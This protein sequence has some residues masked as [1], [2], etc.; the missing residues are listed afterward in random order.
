MRMILDGRVPERRLAI[1][2]GVAVCLL[3]TAGSAVASSTSMSKDE[4]AAQQAAQQI[5]DSFTPPDAP[6][7]SYFGV[8]AG[9]VDPDPSTT[10]DPHPLLTTV[11]NAMNSLD[12]GGFSGA[13]Q[14]PDGVIHVGLTGGG[15]PQLLQTLTSALPG[16]DTQVF[17]TK[18]S[19]TDL[20]TIADDVVD[21]MASDVT[22]T[23]LSV[24]PDIASNAVQ[25]GVTDVNSPIAT[26]IAQ[27]YGDAVDLFRDS[28][29]T[30]LDAAP[31]STPYPGRA[32]HHQPGYA[33]L[34]IYVPKGTPG[35][36]H[37]GACTSGFGYHFG[38]V[39]GP[40]YET[41]FYTAGH[42]VILQ[43]PTTVWDQGGG[44]FGPWTRRSYNP[45]AFLTLADAATITTNNN[46]TI[47]YRDSSNLVAIAP[48]V[49]PVEIT[50]RE[51]LY[52]GAKGDPV[53]VS[54]AISGVRTGTIT[55]GGFGTTFKLSGGTIV[56]SAY[57]ATLTG[58]LKPG[59]SG[60][61]VFEHG[62]ALGSLVGASEA[63]PKVVYYSQIGYVES[64]LG[65]DTNTSTVTY[66]S[67]PDLPRS[68]K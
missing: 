54:G 42:C 16:T 63:N 28:P 32:V 47:T 56:A 36:P 34:Y 66:H 26:A 48:G 17:S 12:P 43:P 60:A 52:K 3:M 25:V 62:V 61:P 19:L 65:V 53:E 21:E 20:L 45:G 27:Q 18:Y 64:T 1:G 2:A 67:S 38:S 35:D 49:P 7:A 29:V 68:A 44:S 10:F 6:T 24:T 50:R 37:G 23:I 31:P 15:T 55:T 41:G 39:S 46:S 4:D 33:G 13:Y 14:T 5:F 59:D 11:Q 58:P 30:P 57:K 22:G 51:G 40:Y 9:Y 8:P